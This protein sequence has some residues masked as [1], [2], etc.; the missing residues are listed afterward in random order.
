[1]ISTL[2]PY[3]LWQWLIPTFT[4]IIFKLYFSYVNALPFLI[5]FAGPTALTVSITENITELSVLVQWGE[6]DDSLP[7]TYVV[8]WTSD[9]TNSTQSHTLIEQSSYTIT[10][11]TLDAVYTI[12]VTATNRC[13]TGPEY[14]TSVS[15]PID[16]FST[17]SISTENPSTAI[18]DIPSVTT[19]TTDVDVD[20]SQTDDEVG[21]SH[22]DVTY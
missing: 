19:S 7:T 2:F 1:M 8:T 14:R 15:L 3:S 11:L 12:T 6:V 4:F 13:G 10:G 20:G 5:L 9:G 22:T 18:S 21:K 17:T 16:A